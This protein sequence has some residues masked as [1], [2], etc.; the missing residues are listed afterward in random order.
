VVQ[1][2][3]QGDFAA[4]CLVSG[5]EVTPFLVAAEVS[6]LGPPSRSSFHR[7]VHR[8]SRFDVFSNQFE[9]AVI[10]AVAEIDTPGETGSAPAGGAETAD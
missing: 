3:N 9:S 1:S 5:L 6:S 4:R 8:L 10:E 2:R 7:S